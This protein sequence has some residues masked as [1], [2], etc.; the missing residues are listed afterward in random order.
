MVL[1]VN[2]QIDIAFVKVCYT[3]QLSHFRNDFDSLGSRD[4]HGKRTGVLVAI[5]RG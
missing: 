5:R 1:Y 4:S 3:C 2:I